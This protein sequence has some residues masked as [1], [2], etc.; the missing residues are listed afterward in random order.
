MVTSR[1][2]GRQC[3]RRQGSNPSRGAK[4]RNAKKSAAEA[5]T[6]CDVEAARGHVAIPN[7]DSQSARALL[8]RADANK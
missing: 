4:R 7:A 8:D 5:Q 3:L 6:S 2:A 1:V